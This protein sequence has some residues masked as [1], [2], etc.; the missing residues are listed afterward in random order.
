MN[1][2][3]YKALHISLNIASIVVL[4]LIV[5]QWGAVWPLRAVSSPIEASLA[6]TCTQAKG[7]RHIAVGSQWSPERKRYEPF[8]KI[9]FTSM[10]DTDKQSIV[11]QVQ[12]RFNEEA[13]RSLFYG[14]HLRAPGVS[15]HHG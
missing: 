3:T 4:L 7:C 9:M 14:S 12:Q 2:E 8:A 1:K 13:G 5:W 10:S 6:K 15:F 11:A